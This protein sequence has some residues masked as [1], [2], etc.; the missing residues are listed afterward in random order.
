M[1]ELTD[2][3]GSDFVEED[4]I[5]GCIDPLLV[6]SD[7]PSAAAAPAVRSLLPITLRI[8]HVR[9]WIWYFHVCSNPTRHER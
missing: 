9:A 7:R 3:R 8:N 2:E 4:L 1:R 5:T 6:I